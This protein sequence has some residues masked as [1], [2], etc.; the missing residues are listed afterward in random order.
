MRRGL[1]YTARTDEATWAHE[2]R[3]EK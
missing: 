2:F 1:G 3:P